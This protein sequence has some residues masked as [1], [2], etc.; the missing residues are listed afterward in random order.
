MI[1]PSKKIDWSKKMSVVTEYAVGLI[2]E[3]DGYLFGDLKYE[4]THR[5][6]DKGDLLIPSRNKK[7]LTIKQNVK[8]SNINLLCFTAW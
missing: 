6:T 1:Q 3:V 5:Q 7:S 4:R 8:P 2:F